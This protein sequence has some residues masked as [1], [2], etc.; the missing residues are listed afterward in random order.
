MS[1]ENGCIEHQYY[2]TF[3]RESE[4]SCEKTAKRRKEKQQV[5]RFFNILL[6]EI[7][8][9]KF[10]SRKKCIELR[11]KRVNSE[12]NFRPFTQPSTPAQV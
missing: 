6:K 9:Q 5:E 1:I 10:Y 8:K 2:Q 3:A 4:Q 12:A 7:Q 11:S